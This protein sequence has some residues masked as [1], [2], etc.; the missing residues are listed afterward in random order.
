MG[1]SYNLTMEYSEQVRMIGLNED[2]HYGHI[3]SNMK[4][5]EVSNMKQNISIVPLVKM[6]LLFFAHQNDHG[7]TIRHTLRCTELIGGFGSYLGLG[8][9]TIQTLEQGAMIHDIGKFF[10]PADVLYAPRKLT[11]EEFSIIQ[12]H[13]QMGGVELHDNDI[14][15]MKEQHHECL[16]GSGYPLG[17]KG[18]EIHPYAQLLSIVDVYDALI[19]PRSYKPAWTQEE[20]RSEMRKHKGTKF[21]AD[22]LERFFVFIDT[23]LVEEEAI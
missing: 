21:N 20:V 8:K 22:M 19:Q 18:A 6:S 14:R 13:P 10:I 23:L 1:M 5:K 3:I 15:A 12:T 2:T 9:K 16:D 11:K 7:E 4:I 17:L